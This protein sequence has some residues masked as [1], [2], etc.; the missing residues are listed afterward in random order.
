LTLGLGFNRQST[1]EFDL[2]YTA[3]SGAGRYNLTN[4][5]DFVGVNVKY[6]F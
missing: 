1:W 3:F 5:R 6:S 2:S 4:D